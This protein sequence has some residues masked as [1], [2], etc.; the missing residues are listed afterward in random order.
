MAAAVD[1]GSSWSCEVKNLKWKKRAKFWK[2]VRM[3]C[4]CVCFID[5]WRCK[6]ILHATTSCHSC[7]FSTNGIICI[8]NISKTMSII[9][10]Q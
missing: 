4:V 6:E 9:I 2:L 1:G 5:D 8:G 7:I 3:V 10:V